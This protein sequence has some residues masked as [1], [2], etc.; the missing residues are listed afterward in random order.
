M[1]MG[2]ERAKQHYVPQ[3]YLRLFS[4]E[5]KGDCVYCYDKA[6]K[7]S[8][9]SSTRQICFE[10]GFYEDKNKTNKPIEKAFSICEKE[11]R[12]LL[13]KIVRAEDLSVLNTK[14]FADFLAFL[15]LFKQRTR[16]RRDIVGYARKIWV[17]RINSRFSDW[18]VVPKSNNWQQSDHLLSMVDTF[19][20]E[21]ESLCRNNWG[22]LVNQT[23]IPFWTS[24]DPLVQQLVRNDERF[25]EPYVKNYFPLNPSMLVH[26]EPVI[27]NDVEVLRAAVTSELVINNINRLTLKNAHRFVISRDNSFPMEGHPP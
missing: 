11:C 18:K 26:S 6:N 16:K 7:K 24:D 19:E 27:G 8:F 4:P 23:K 21:I 9:R 2:K 13:S 14:E 20:P 17:E 1:T 25:G 10:N 12:V 22:L 3:F 5:E 15:L